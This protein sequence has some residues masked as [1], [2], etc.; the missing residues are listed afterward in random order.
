[1]DAEKSADDA[2]AIGHDAARRRRARFRA[3]HRG[4]REMDLM[5]G[6]YADAHVDGLDEAGLDRFEHLM[7]EIDTDLLK[8]VVGQEEP[9]PHIDKELLGRII[10]FRHATARSP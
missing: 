9:P 2:I 4:I 7:E 5:L 6:P 3:W 10:A 1:M 8:W